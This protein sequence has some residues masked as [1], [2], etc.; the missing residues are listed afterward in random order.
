ME[1]WV[2][3]RKLPDHRQKYSIA[4]VQ[5]TQDVICFHSPKSWRLELSSDLSCSW[6][7]QD[8]NPSWHFVV[9]NFP[10]LCCASRYC[11]VCSENTEGIYRLG[12]TIYCISFLG[13]YNAHHSI[14]ASRTPAE[15]KAV[16]SYLLFPP[17][18]SVVLAH[19]EDRRGGAPC[20]YV[21][22]HRWGTRY[23]LWRWKYVFD[24]LIN[25]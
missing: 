19:A 6:Q 17:R 5:R 23:C 22:T 24:E 11:N 13:V 25:F 3:P 14:K 20:W 10:T 9:L 7:S 4:S 21:F 15:T 16:N 1:R 18:I 12:V 2:L 8:Q